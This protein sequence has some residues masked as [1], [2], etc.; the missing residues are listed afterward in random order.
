MYG[1]TQGSVTSALEDM[2]QG[3]I[4]RFTDGSGVVK[5]K[6]EYY[7]F[8]KNELPEYESEGAGVFENIPPKYLES[9]RVDPDQL[10]GL[11]GRFQAASK[12]PE[13]LQGVVI[14]D[15]LS[16]YVNYHYNALNDALR[17]LK[18]L[19]PELKAMVDD[20]D[21]LILNN[22][23]TKREVFRGMHVGGKVFKVGDVLSDPA[24]GSASTDIDVAKRFASSRGVVLKIQNAEGLWIGGTESELLLA[25]K[26]SFEVVSVDSSVEPSRVVVKLGKM[27]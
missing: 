23:S 16:Q 13:D 9:M 3:V 15:S 4:S 8:N 1:V 24:F 10:D 18:P 21:T 22:V 14:E 11:F 17:S 26:T 2:E 6:E 25:R 5:F 12:S 27:R 20:I 7:R 19:K